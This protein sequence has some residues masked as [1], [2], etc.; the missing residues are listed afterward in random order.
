MSRQQKTFEIV[1]DIFSK[2]KISI[3]DPIFINELKE[4]SG[5]EAMKFAIPKMVGKVPQIQKLF[6]AIEANPALTK[7]NNLLAF[8]YFMDEWAGGNI[9]ISNIEPWNEFR[10]NVKLGLTEIL[11][12]TGKGETIGTFTS[13]GTISAITAEALQIKDEKRVAAMNFSVRNTSFSVFLFSKN[14]FNLLSFNE[15]PHLPEEMIT[16]V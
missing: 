8:Q 6:E 12:N 13:G 5:T 4:H 15:L 11:E 1:A 2:N 16:F 7:R 9:E 14:K 3:P 10:K